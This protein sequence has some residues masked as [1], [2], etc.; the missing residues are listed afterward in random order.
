MFFSIFVSPIWDP[1][2][3]PAVH[4]YMGQ[5]TS[6]QLLGQQQSHFA[7]FRLKI[8]KKNTMTL[9]PTQYK[10]SEYKKKVCPSMIGLT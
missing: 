4:V 1:S 6:P 2:I 8:M 5:K 9:L 7:F 3:V 10:Y